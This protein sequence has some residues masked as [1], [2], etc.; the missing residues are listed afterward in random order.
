ME[1]EK[2]AEEL[3]VAVKAVHMACSLCG[4]V[5]RGLISRTSDEVKSKDDDSPVT[6][7]GI[8][9][10]ILAVL[11][12]KVVGLSGLFGFCPFGRPFKWDVAIGSASMSVSQICWIP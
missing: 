3:D 5:Q 7:A 10:F 2:Y 9:L 12:F 6:V 8:S 11:E 1:D 4:R